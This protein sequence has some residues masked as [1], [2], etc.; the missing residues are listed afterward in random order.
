MDNDFDEIFENVSLSEYLITDVEIIFSKIFE[1]KNCTSF[2]VSKNY[3]SMKNK[4]S[5]SRTELRIKKIFTNAHVIENLSVDDS[6][7]LLFVADGMT[8]NNTIS[9]MDYWVL[10]DCRE[11][12]KL[13]DIVKVFSSHELEFQVNYLLS[14]CS[15][16]LRIWTGSRYKTIQVFKKINT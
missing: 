16:C 15:I 14:Y 5:V 2:I 1:K 9:Y 10:E 6:I 8:T 3:N 12:L 11:N 4:L 7:F 13:N